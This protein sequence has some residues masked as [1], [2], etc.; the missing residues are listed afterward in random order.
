MAMTMLVEAVAAVAAEAA[1]RSMS[2]CSV[3]NQHKNTRCAGFCFFC[4]AAV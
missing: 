4:E 1:E 2:N 3:Q